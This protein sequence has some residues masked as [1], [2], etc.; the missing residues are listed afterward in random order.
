MDN[1]SISSFKRPLRKARVNWAKMEAEEDEKVGLQAV[2]KGQRGGAQ[3]KKSGQ[4][5]KTPKVVKNTEDAGQWNV[6]LKNETVLLFHRVTS[7]P[8]ERAGRDLGGGPKKRKSGALDDSSSTIKFEGLPRS[9]KKKEEL[10]D[11]L[12]ERAK[13]AYEEVKADP[14]NLSPHLV[15]EGVHDLGLVP[16]VTKTPGSQKYRS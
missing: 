14:G 8:G 1:S 6:Q 3:G 12:F 13:E 11:A 7:R 10:L 4:V 9:G 15:P 5:S 2:E 16:I